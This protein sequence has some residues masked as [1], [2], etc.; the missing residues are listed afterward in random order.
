MKVLMFGWEFPPYHSGGLGTACHGLTRGLANANVDVTLVL[1]HATEDIDAD[2]LTA[3]SVGNL[4]QVRITAALRPYLTPAAYAP[5]TNS[6]YGQDLFEEVERY[7][8]HASAVAQHEQ[9]DIIHAHDWMT[10]KAGI[11]AKEKTK[12]PLVVHVHATEFDRTGG[13]GIHP[14]VSRIEGDGMRAADKVIAVSQFTKQKIVDFYGIPEQ[15]IEVVHNA[16]DF[17]VTLPRAR[18]PTTKTVVLFLGRITLQKGPD[19]FIAAARRVLEHDDH[20]LFIL[21]GSGDME[22]Q[23]IEQAAAG[24][25][26]DRVLFTG[27][28]RGEDVQRAYRMADI[29]VMPSVSEPFGI[30]PLEAISC[31]V[32][33]IISKQSGVS[34]V[35]THCLKVDFWDVEELANKIISLARSPEAQHCMRRNAAREVA[36]LDWTDAAEQ[37]RAIYEEML[38]W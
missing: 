7:A 21:A 14:Q 28:L 5:R 23:V 13:N 35:I 27:F 37:C 22:A 9:F 38:P 1:P 33:C 26:A 19:Y 16:V 36:A 6:L 17:P 34:E 24:G 32:P 2:F 3:V 31:G 4:K 8:Q 15:K 11:A 25:I 30:T 10:F 12:K 20:F 29:Y 18:F